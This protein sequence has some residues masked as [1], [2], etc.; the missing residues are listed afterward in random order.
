LVFNK[1]PRNLEAEIAALG[2]SVVR[3]LHEIDA[4]LVT[5]DSEGFDVAVEGLSGVSSVIPDLCLERI[6]TVA[7]HEM[8]V[9]SLADDEPYSFLQWDLEAIDAPGAWDLGYTGQGVRVAIIDTGIDTDHPD[10]AP[11]IDVAASASMIAYEP[12]IEDVDGHGSNVAGIVAAADNGIGVIGVAPNAEIIAIKVFDAS[13]LGYFSWTLLGILH[14]VAVDA[15]I[16]NMSLGAYLAHSQ[17]PAN[18]INAFLN[19]LRSTIDYANKHGILVVASAGNESWDGTGDRGVL[20]IPS[21]SGK[22]VC[23]SA[24]GPVGWTPGS[25]V[26]LDGFS[27][28]SNYGPEIDFAAPG[29]DYQ[30]HPNG[31]WYLDMVL[32]CWAGG[33]SWV[34]GTSQAAPHVAGVAAL[35]IE[36][37][38]GDMKPAH[39]LR[40]LRR[41]ADDLGKP[42]QDP[43][44]GYGRVNAARAVAP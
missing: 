5:S 3:V 42:G 17:Q 39:I 18:E 7:V 14:A 26:D 36:K 6:P 13:G 37:N 19:L 38:G 31:T 32:N 11:N 20:H 27:S 35:I 34:A 1:M 40:E 44:Y 8:D 9:E 2:G 23:V 28:Y 24:T 10:L 16:I 15:D 30:L 29:G 22:T 41:S 4:A 25:A 33:W 43:Y 21:D 12:S